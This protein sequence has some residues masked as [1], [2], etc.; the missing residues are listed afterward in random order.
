LAAI[1]ATFILC[2]SLVAPGAPAAA[3]PADLCTDQI[4]ALEAVKAQIDAHNAAPHVFLIPDQQAAANAYNAEA[5][6]L[7]AA[8]DA[9]VANLQ[10]CTDAMEALANADS[11]TA[12]LPV[13][14]D[15]VK[16]DIDAAKT[17][18]PAGWT[19]PAPP[20]AGKNW[21]VPMNSPL[22]PLYDVLRENNPGPLGTAVLRS[23]PRPTV[24]AP[25]PAY[26]TSTGRV[27]GTNA[28][29][30]SAA[31]PDHI[32]PLAEI[33]N[34]P[35]F[36]KL[37]AQN[38]YAVS[39]AP[40]NYQWLSWGANLSKQSRSVAAMSGVDPGWQASQVRLENEVRAQLQDIIDKLLKSQ[41]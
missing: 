30:A 18:I 12:D 20:A 15:N 4:A 41:G 26:P 29:G 24:G 5:Q 37:N 36:T 8:R 19:P 33:V 32:I 16:T 34:L 22:R 9:A 3:E 10:T 7:N 2:L 23:N 11:A 14:P 27:F 39:R 35:N 1:V 31:S 25:D 6:Q 40:L 38:M 13:V 17:Q 28:G 21:R